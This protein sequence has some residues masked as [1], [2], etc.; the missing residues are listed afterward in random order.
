MSSP[1]LTVAKGIAGGRVAYGLACMFLPRRATGPA[2][3]EAAGP[4]RWMVRAFGVRDLVLGAATLRALQQDGP[5]AAAWVEAG[6]AAD[7]LDLA[8]AAVFHR[9][10]DRAGVLGVLGLALP[11]TLG[12]LWAAAKLRAA[13]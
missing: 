13:R 6:A 2:G 4:M 5:A 9:E 1:E 8:N 11:A 7:A 3:A 10:L 12:G